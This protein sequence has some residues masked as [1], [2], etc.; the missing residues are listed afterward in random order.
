[1]KTLINQ[2]RFPGARKAALP[3]FVPP[4]LA[5]LVKV[6]PDGDAWVHE[7]KFDG[8]RMLCR[9]E[10][11]EVRFWSRNHKDWTLKFPGLVKAMASFPAQAAMLDGEVVILD[12]AGRTSFQA[13]QKSLGRTSKASFIYQIFDLIHLDGYNLAAVPLVKRK[14]LLQTLF[15]SR[16]LA[17]SLRYSDH[18]Q[19]NGGEFFDKA[20]NYG[21]EGVVSK[22]ADSP[23]ESARTRNWLKAKCIKRQEFVVAGY[24]PTEKGLPG[25]GALVLGIYDRGKLLYAGRVGTGFTFKQ[26]TD[27][28]KKLDPLVT[29]KMPFAV[30]PKDPGLRNA[31]WTTPLL[32]AEVEFTEWTDDGA[33][34][35]PSFQ[36]LR[37][38]K[39]PKEI[40]RETATD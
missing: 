22:R 6:P 29:G 38:D 16:E 37:E 23:Y 4:Q 39:N 1:M 17:S 26:R 36:G 12:A 9:L 30:K 34:R 10:R 13:L 27:L 3:E 2:K 20:C 5:T 32:V 21:I 31:Q 19:G 18:V 25:F 15:E 8:Y 24:T 11:G 14:K 28:R 35:H 33:V 7:L 40:V